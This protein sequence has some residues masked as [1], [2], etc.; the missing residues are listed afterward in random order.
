MNYRENRALRQYDGLIKRVFRMLSSQFGMEEA[1]RLSR[2]IRFEYGKIIPELPDIGGQAVF[3][4]FMTGTGWALAMY[5][6]GRREGWSIEQCGQLVFDVTREYLN[7][8]P[9]VVHQ[10]MRWVSN[11]RLYRNRIRE[12][13]SRSLRHRVPDGYVF[14][15]SEGD[16]EFDYGVDYFE[17]ASCKFLQKQGGM[18]IAPYLC[19]A[20]YI[21]SELWGWGLV[22]SQTLACGSKKCDFRFKTGGETNIVLNGG[23][24]V[25]RD[26]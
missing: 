24:R 19:N 3:Q 17:C 26:G 11:S 2:E 5:R 21:Y 20:D 15:Y 8:F 22:R 6:A 4:L 9:P 7:S 1:E 10:L 18:E 23:V 25:T 14:N 13:A 12:L 16:S